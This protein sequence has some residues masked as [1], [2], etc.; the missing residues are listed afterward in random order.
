MNNIVIRSITGSPFCASARPRDVP[1][2]A[3]KSIRVHISS[4]LRG[5]CP[6]PPV[7]DVLRQVARLGAGAIDLE[8]ARKQ[9]SWARA[10]KGT[11]SWCNRGLLIAA[12]FFVTAG[13]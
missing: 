13:A 3:R 5:D 10:A 1:Q 11:Q 2:G 12:K 8:A 7:E 6:P 4:S 9:S